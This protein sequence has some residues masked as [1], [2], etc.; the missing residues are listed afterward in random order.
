MLKVTSSL[1]KIASVTFYIKGSY[2]ISQPKDIDRIAHELW[3]W[4]SQNA[5]RIL[6][7]FKPE[8]IA[9]D[10]FELGP[11]GVINWYVPEGVDPKEIP[12]YIDQ[13]I[14][15]E[16]LPL[17]INIQYQLDKSKMFNVPVWRLK[18]TENKTTE[19]QRLP[20]L[21][22]SNR[23]AAVLLEHLKLN[24]ELA[25][26][27]NAYDLLERVRSAV[28]SEPSNL[29]DANNG[30]GDRGVVWFDQGISPEQFN[31]YLYILEQIATHAISMNS[32]V[33]EWA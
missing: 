12:M 26:E 31:R 20:E 23:N 33:V 5:P 14:Q 8:P 2:K 9:M 21:N 13:Y 30:I 7:S 32:P 11:L 18:V 1:I 6:T 15:E 10:G 3:T 19:H 22:V 17:G 4:A 16:A 28:S 27:I 29:P 25:G 24:T